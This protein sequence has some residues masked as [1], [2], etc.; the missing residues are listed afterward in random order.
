MELLV[1]YLG[2]VQFEAET[3]GHKL[4]CDQPFDNKGD[5]EGMTPPE[6]LLASL[7]TCAGY[8]AVEYLRSRNL[9]VEGVRVKIW[10][11]KA[12]N[13]AR[14][15]KFKIDVEAPELT[16]PKHIEGV[17]RSV[18]KCLIKNTLLVPPEIE[19]EIKSLDKVAG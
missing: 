11:E 1:N 19:V 4:I 15:G 9:P 13:P 17:R 16:D 18:E 5:D 8:Y 2:N 10:A 7:A 12:K 14:L 3:R 6:L